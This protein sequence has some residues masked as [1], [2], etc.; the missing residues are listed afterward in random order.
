MCCDVMYAAKDVLMWINAVYIVN[1]V[2][3]LCYI[4]K[5]MCIRVALIWLS[6]D[7]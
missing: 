5:P 4:D 2:V 3:P 6:P 1:P 7:P